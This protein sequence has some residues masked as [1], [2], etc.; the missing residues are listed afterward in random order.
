MERKVGSCNSCLKDDERQSPQ[1]DNVSA[2][3]PTSVR[4]KRKLRNEN[5]HQFHTDIS[6]LIPI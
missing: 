6:S 2:V 4:A 3:R 5:S 1:S